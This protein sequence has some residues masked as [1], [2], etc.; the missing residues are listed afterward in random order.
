MLSQDTMKIIKSTVPVLEQHGNTITTVFYKNMFEAHP[1]LLNVFNSVNQSQGRQQAALANTVYAAAANID[2]L[3]AIMP[4]VIQIAHKHKSLGITKDQYP[5]V[6]YYLLGAIKEVLGDA[7]TP[8]IIAAWGEA[9]GVIADVFINIEDVMYADAEQM[10]GGWRTFKDFTI[11]NKVV[12]SEVITSFYLKPVDGMKLPSYK[13]GQYISLRINIPGEKN[14]LIRQ[15]SLS[16]AENGEEYRISVKREQDFEP[17]GKVS[18]HLHNQ[19]T[20]GDTIEVSIPA[21]VFHLD[22]EN[23]TPVTLISGGVG[24]TPMMSMYET[25]AKET[26]NRPVTFLHSARSRSHHA[27]GDRLLKLNASLTNSNYAVLYSEEGDGFISHEFL[28]T[29]VL[30]GSDVYVCGPTPFMQSVLRDLYALGMP[31]DKVH[32]EFFGP[33]VQLELVEA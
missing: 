26:P 19:L 27:F 30:E 16:Q 7:A 25:I 9:Y 14:T 4:T 8:E 28:A 13:P 1:E 10:D 31:E 17:N 2:N 24:I 5:I 3:A 15:Y 6:G 21:G 20:V 22:V 29:N 23:T 11:E 32:F 12:E 33:A 18:C